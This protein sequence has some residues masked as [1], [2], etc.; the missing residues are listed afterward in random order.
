VH[1][2]RGYQGDPLVLPWHPGESPADPAELATISR[3]YFTD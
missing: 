2:I 3:S 1:V